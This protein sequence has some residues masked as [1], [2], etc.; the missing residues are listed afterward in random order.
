MATIDEIGQEKQ[1]LS[2]RL[3]RLDAERAKVAD[4]LNELE[5]AERVDR[6]RGGRVH[7]AGS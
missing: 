7:R 5:V 2:D 1:K 6:C 3:V 4:Q